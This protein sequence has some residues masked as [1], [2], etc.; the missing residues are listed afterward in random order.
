[1]E[2]G[3]KF[4]ADTDGFIT[5][6]RFYRGAG[7]AGTTFAGHL[8]AANGTLLA[9]ATFPT[10]TQA[11]WQEVTFITPVP[12]TAGATYVASYHTSSGYAIDTGYFTIANQS[13][14]TNP[15]LRA[16][17][18]R[19]DGPNGVYRY[20]PSGRFPNRGNESNYWIDVVFTG[21]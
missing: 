2:L 11:G 18:N 8:W 21:D 14:Y 13:S 12:I 15:P 7:N 16:L 6:L 19:E 17:V 4:R 3:V 20:G 1:V 10:G 5:G 9:G